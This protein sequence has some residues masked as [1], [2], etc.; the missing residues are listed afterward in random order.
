MKDGICILINT[1]AGLVIA[2]ATLTVFGVYSMLGQ[3]LS[4]EAGVLVILMMAL[5]ERRSLW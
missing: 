5:I 2:T 1:L 4:F 3:L